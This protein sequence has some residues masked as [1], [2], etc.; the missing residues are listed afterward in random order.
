[1]NRIKQ[2][3]AFLICAVILFTGLNINGYFNSFFYAANNFN[4]TLTPNTNGYGSVS[5]DWSSYAY[6]DKNFKVYKSSDGGKTYETVG[7]DYALVDE[8]KCC[9]RLLQ[10]TGTDRKEA[11]CI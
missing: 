7:I 3:I 4:I 2:F 9:F 11:L 8:V 5:L 1:M 10:R 6:Q